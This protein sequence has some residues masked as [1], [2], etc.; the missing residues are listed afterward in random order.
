MM[1]QVKVKGSTIKV[2]YSKLA[3]YAHS[4]GSFN[5]IFFKHGRYIVALEVISQCEE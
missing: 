4:F 1:S 2:K 5:Q 3:I